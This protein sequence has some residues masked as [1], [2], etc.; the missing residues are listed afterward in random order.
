MFS[1]W[2]DQKKPK[3]F[4]VSLSFD[5]SLAFVSIPLQY[6]VA[7]SSGILSIVVVLAGN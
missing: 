1:V 4:P 7:V 5:L 3:K 2:I 6:S